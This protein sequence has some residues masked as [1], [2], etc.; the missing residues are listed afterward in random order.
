MNME[1]RIGRVTLRFELPP[2]VYTALPLS[3]TGKTYTARLLQSIEDEYSEDILVL[4]YS[5]LADM[6][7]EALC[8][9]IKSAKYKLIFADRAD[10]YITKGVYECLL[11]SGAVVYLDCKDNNSDNDIVGKDCDIEFTEQEIVYSVDSF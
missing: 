11:K 9:R 4:T 2:G 5:H 1:Y 8:K 3:S 6:S 10:L 7:E